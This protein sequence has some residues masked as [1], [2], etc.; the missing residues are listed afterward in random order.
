LNGWEGLYQVSNLGNIKSL[1]RVIK[2]QYDLKSGTLT[3]NRTVPGKILKFNTNPNGYHQVTLSGQSHKT[4]QVVVHRLVAKAFI[5]NPDNLP[6]VNHKDECKVNNEVSNLE[7]CD[8][9]YNILYS[10]NLHPGRISKNNTNNPKRSKQVKC[11]ETGIIYPSTKEAFRQTGI[12]YGNIGNVCRKAK[13]KDKRGY[14][15]TSQTAGGYH[16]EYIK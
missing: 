5:P 14:Y 3:C 13:I 11:V 4:K 1:D 6:F 16:W 12:S 7:W 9:K 8:H 2:G 15:Y 10:C